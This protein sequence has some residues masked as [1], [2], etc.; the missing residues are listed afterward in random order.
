M[1]ASFQRGWEARIRASA[2]DGVQ[3][4]GLD[5]DYFLFT[6][7]FYAQGYLDRAEYRLCQR[8]YAL[9]RNLMGAP[10][11]I[12]YLEA[13]LEVIVARYAARGRAHEI[14]TQAELAAMQDLLDEWLGGVVSSPVIRV[15]A[16]VEDPG[17]STIGPSVL[18]EIYAQ[19]G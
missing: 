6:R 9:L 8:I 18:A 4:G 12:V 17:Y 5:L 11:V 10:D 15:D 2:R 1:A 7:H 13:P 3:D 19:L 16:S 14:T